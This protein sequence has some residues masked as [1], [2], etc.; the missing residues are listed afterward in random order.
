M[1]KKNVWC[2][3]S[4]LVNVIMLLLLIINLVT[5]I[6]HFLFL[7]K[8]ILVS[9]SPIIWINQMICKANRILG[10]IRHTCND[11]QDPLTCYFFYLAHVR[12]IL[13]YGSEICNPF[14]KS[15]ITAIERV[16]K[17]CY[18]INPSKF[19][20]I[21]R[22]SKRTQ[23][24]LVLRTDQ[25]FRDNILLFKGLHGMYFISLQDRMKFSG[26]ESIF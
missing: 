1:Q 13:E 19:C 18:Q 7:V 16:S 3:R 23:P 14:T 24:F 5:T 25:I 8:T 6:I 12:T 20:P 22:A 21:W 4:K 10:L 26:T 9:W 17:A 11:V 2:F 15:L